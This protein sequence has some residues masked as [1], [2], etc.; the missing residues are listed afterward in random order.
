MLINELDH[1]SQLFDLA[2]PRTGLSPSPA[3]H[4]LRLTFPGQLWGR[5][6]RRNWPYRLQF[7]GASCSGATKEHGQPLPAVTHA[8]WRSVPTRVN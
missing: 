4:P 1:V 7:A 5:C 6:L 2:P 8:V 3:S